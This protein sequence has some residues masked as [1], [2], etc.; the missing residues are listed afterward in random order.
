MNKKLAILMVA[1]SI[2]ILINGINTSQRLYGS[3][4][5]GTGAGFGLMITVAELRQSNPIPSNGSTGQNLNPTLSITVNDSQGHA[6]NVVFRTNASGSWVTMGSNISVYNGTY[7]QAP[8]NMNG[9]RTIYW[10]SIIETDG[11]VWTNA[12]YHFTTTGQ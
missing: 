9:E 5:G 10:W 11:T 2:V 3:T 7:N 8:F 4:Y 6:M 1:I 12:T